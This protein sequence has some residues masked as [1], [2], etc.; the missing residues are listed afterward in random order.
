[1]DATRPASGRAANLVNATFS[2]GEEGTF[3]P[4]V[5]AVDA[6]G[7]RSP[8]AKF[9]AAGGGKDAPLQVAASNMP[10]MAENM[11]LAASPGRAVAIA[12]RATDGDGNR[13]TFV[14][15]SGPSHGM[16]AGTA[17]DL[18]YTPD[19]SFAGTDSFTFKATDGIQ[20]SLPA[21]VSI[22]VAEPLA[23]QPQEEEE[24]DLLQ[25]LQPDE[26]P[27]S[28]PVAYGQSVAATEDIPA[29]VTIAATDADGDWLEYSI[30]SEPQHGF[31]SGSAPSFTYV[32]DNEYSGPDSFVFVA[33]DSFGGRSAAAT[34]SITVAEVN[35]MPYAQGDSAT[36]DYGMP[37]AI[38]VLANDWDIETEVLSI[39][40]TS[41]PQQQGS[42]V[43]IAGSMITYTPGAGFSGIDSFSYTVSDGSGGTATA[44]VWVTVSAPPPPPAPPASQS[45]P[46]QPPAPPSSSPPPPTAEPQP[47]PQPPAPPPPSSSPPATELYCGREMSSFASVVR[48]TEGRDELKGT[49]GDDLLLGFGGRD[50]LRGKGGNDCLIGGQGDDRMFGDR[51]H[52]WL[53]GGDGNDSMWGGSEDDKMWGGSDKVIG[54]DGADLVY[55]DSGNDLLSGD[56]GD[57]TLYDKEGDDTLDGGAGI[58]RGYDKE[59]T[60]QILSCER[61]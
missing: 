33:L 24:E 4:Q 31:L 46:E 6:A 39:A 56:G 42:T 10:P 21:T 50:V 40:S 30:V 45:P 61:T 58:D 25:L 1:M 35:D 52:D 19:A 3:Y 8:W 55:G 5:R 20:E 38:D 48:G 22:T 11:T 34:V 27:N 15:V 37:V 28:P 57:D 17:P 14:V 7:A 60:N 26:L 18:T 9:V 47:A 44:T 16:L 13:I 36:T 54:D 51:G 12:L 32:P 59:G 41:S 2:Y 43:T 53:E 23:V 29:H 49:D